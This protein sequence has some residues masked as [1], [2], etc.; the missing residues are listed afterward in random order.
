VGAATALVSRPV[1]IAWA[2]EVA[3][4]IPALGP[5]AGPACVAR[6]WAACLLRPEGR[7]KAYWPDILGRTWNV[8]RP[9]LAKM[10]LPACGPGQE[11]LRHE[12]AVPL[13][14]VFL[15]S[16]AAGRKDFRLLGMGGADRPDGPPFGWAPGIDSVS[17]FI[18]YLVA[19][20]VPGGFQSHALLASPLARVVSAA[21]LAAAVTVAQW[22][23]PRCGGGVAG[24]AGRCPQCG[25][26]AVQV[27]VRRLVATSSLGLGGADVPGPKARRPP[28]S[29]AGAG[30]GGLAEAD[31]VEAGAVQRQCAVRAR[32]L[33]ERVVR[34][35]ASNVPAMVVLGAMAGVQPLVLVADRPVPCC[36]WLE[37]LVETLADRPLDRAR[38]VHEANGAMAVI[39][40][41]LGLAPP[42]PLRGPYVGVLATRFRR[43][44]LGLGLS[45]PRP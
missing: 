14:V 1:V 43:V 33:W 20:Q 24:G 4:R 31:R 21:G 10:G 29:S 44:V 18:R 37:R 38:L 5:A 11:D 8:I 19:G 13:A 35:R 23:C 6:L 3:G 2:R 34:G 27:R 28:A 17:P 9:M 15:Q 42:P 36:A 41:R 16:L 22:R 32:V 26:L 45:G 39:A 7:L 40:G 30:R 12:V 25:A